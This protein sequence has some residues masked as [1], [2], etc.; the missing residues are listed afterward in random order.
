MEKA[1]M[2]GVPGSAP[3]N[4]AM[5]KTMLALMD[6]CKAVAQE[7]DL[8]R[9]LNKILDTAMEFTQCRAGTLYFREGECLAFK[10]VRN[11]DRADIEEKGVAMPPVPLTSQKHLCSL[12]ASENKTISISDAYLCKHYDLSGTKRYDERN[13]YH[14]QSVLVCP[15]MGDH[16]QCLAV[17][18]LINA[19]DCKGNICDFSNT[20]ELVEA[21]A[22]NISAALQNV[23]FQSALENILGVK[24]VL[25]SSTVS[26]PLRKNTLNYLNESYYDTCSLGELERIAKK[27]NMD[28][29]ILSAKKEKIRRDIAAR[30]NFHS[31]P[32]EVEDIFQRVW[33]RAMNEKKISPFD[34]I[35][36]YISA[37]NLTNAEIVRKTGLDKSMVSRLCSG[38]SALTKKTLFRFSMGLCLRMEQSLEL[39]SSSG[40]I[41]R[42]SNLLDAFILSWLAYNDAATCAINQVDLEAIMA[43]YE[44][45][46]EIIRNSKK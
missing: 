24:R 46:E 23:R 27:T 1:I 5:D 39:M 40:Y 20:Q 29:K 10:L 3:D 36:A 15:I 7:T 30:A 25:E 38:K 44:K 16:Q 28:S 45:I 9:L 18:Q 32:V 33:D 17:L 13:Q 19:T 35:M 41:L 21:L 12:A 14:T 2:K 31:A 37:S 26:E 34:L 11:L 42:D 22:D 43:D 4:I 8:E 6:I